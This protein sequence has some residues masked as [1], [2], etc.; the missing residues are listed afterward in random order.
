MKQKAQR[1]L[2]IFPIDAMV[3]LIRHATAIGG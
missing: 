1:R 2:D 3:F